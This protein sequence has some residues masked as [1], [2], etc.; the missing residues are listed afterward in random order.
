MTDVRAVIADQ[1][2]WCVA[3]QPLFEYL[4]SRPFPLFRPTPERHIAND[5]SA[6]I[7]LCYWLA[8]AHD[9]MGYNYEGWGNT[10]TLAAK[11]EPI[12]IA[13]ALPGDVVIYGPTWATVHGAMIVE[14]SPTNPLTMSH[15]EPDQPALVRLIEG[16]PTPEY[17]PRC[18]RFDTSSRFPP[19]PPP[20]PVVARTLSGRA[21][22]LGRCAW[23]TTLDWPKFD[24][25]LLFG[26]GPKAV[27]WAIDAGGHVRV[28]VAK[29]RRGSLITVDVYRKP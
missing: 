23:N 10:D 21:N 2:R 4:E 19:P 27:T 18:F 6:T 5:C 28:R 3:N 29:A 15:G 14:P 16:N 8:G 25:L 12:S 24:H 9:P 13:E 20:A 17:E 26:G 22:L 11:G 7:A 1:A